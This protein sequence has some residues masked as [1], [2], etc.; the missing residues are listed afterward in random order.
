MDTQPTPEK[1][2]KL[3]K[4]VPKKW[5]ADYDRVVGYHVMGK[6]NIEIAVALRFTPE[7]VSTILN[8]PQAQ[9]LKKK[10]EAKLREKMEVNIPD[11]LDY[12]A[13]KGAER[14]KSMVDNDE[15]FEKSPF[16]VI[17]RAMDVM[18]GLN[19][20]KGGGN[21]SGPGAINVERAIIVSGAAGSQLV[22]GFSKAD[23]ARRINGS[24]VTTTPAQIERE[25]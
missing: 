20:L 23:E 21:G 14:L 5:K 24:P 3:G 25:G 12:V 10:L 11:T 19:H 13:R 4:W 22:E 7:H 9:E 15:L 16:A 18:K 6:Q 2:G 1:K 17:D 8:L